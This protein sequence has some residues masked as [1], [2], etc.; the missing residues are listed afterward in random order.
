MIG[1]G[2]RRR[3]A[4]LAALALPAAAGLGGCGFTPMYAQPGLSSGL[5]HIEVVA[6]QGREGY[7]LGDDLS[8]ALG[9]NRDDPPRYRLELAMMPGRAGHG[10]TANDTAQRYELDLK[11]VFT[12]IDVSTG[13][14]VDTGQAVSN[15]SYDSVNQP[16][17]GIMARQDVQDRLAS[18]AAQKI[19]IALAAW[20]A[21][22]PNG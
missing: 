14:V 10:L 4:A 9:R 16:Y 7:L 5:T 18:D 19:E 22:H 21:S 12:L 3:W 15:V 6:P 2:A 13:K 1:G 8:D 17:A 11:V 20:L